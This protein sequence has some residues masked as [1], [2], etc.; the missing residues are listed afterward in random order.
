[1]TP[2]AVVDVSAA[3]DSQHLF[4]LIAVDFEL[5]LYQDG[6][7]VLGVGKAQ[8]SV[9]HPLRRASRYH[10]RYNNNDG[11]S[12][13]L[14]FQLL[15]VRTQSVVRYELN[16]ATIAAPQVLDLQFTFRTD[17]GLAIPA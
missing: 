16:I 10:I 17:A 4:H 1:M 8:P 3:P 6:V 11:G 5:R 12:G 2:T 7:E 15:E 14:H 9:R 13:A